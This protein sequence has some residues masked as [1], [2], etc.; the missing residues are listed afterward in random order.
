MTGA[1]TFLVFSACAA[2]ILFAGRGLSRYGDRIAELTGLGGAWVGLILMAAVTSL[3]ELM[4]SVSSVALVGS[5]DLAVGNV[6]GS[7]A[8]NLIILAGLDAFVPARRPLL[9]VASASHVLAAALGIILLALVGI[10]LLD[11]D[12]TELTAWIGVSSVVFIV[13]YLASVRLLYLHSLRIGSDGSIQPPLDADLVPSGQAEV[14]A[15]PARQVVLRYT[16]YAVVIVAAA[17]ALPPLAEQIAVLTGLRESFVGTLLLAAST[18]LPEIAVSLAAVR[19]GAID[20]AVGNLLGSNLF[21]ILILAL[22]DLAYVRGI[23]LRDASDL[24]LVSVLATIGMSAIVIIG[25]TFRVR[26]KRFLLAWD[27][28]LIVAVYV[29]NLLLLLSLPG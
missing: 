11:P 25:L 16:L 5:A 3:P 14:L 4:V 9:S 22:G 21:N 1:V 26:G 24:H 2:V 28:A 18:S 6:I 29:G 13:V 15:L 20:L 17:M 10:G 19:M 27:A 7:C 23:L 12:E 8:F